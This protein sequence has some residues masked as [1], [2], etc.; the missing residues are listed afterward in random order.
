MKQF[1]HI[2]DLACSGDPDGRSYRQVNLAKVHAIPIGT[3]VEMKRGV[4]LFVVHHHR[5]CD[6][7]PLYA[8]SADPDDTI[9]EDDRFHN[10]K[11]VH[12]WPE[13]ALKVVDPQPSPDP[14][15]LD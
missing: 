13:E 10:Q 12:G 5:D 7:T 6:G 8:M 4:R 1:I 3:L 9:Q 15:G 11:W 2:A 14:D